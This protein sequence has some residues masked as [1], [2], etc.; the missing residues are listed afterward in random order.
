MN[1]SLWLDEATTA[2]VSKMSFVEI[3]TKFLPNDFHPPFYYLFMKYWVNIFGYS[4]ISLRLPSVIFA[5]LTVYLVYKMFG[6]I[7][8]ILLATA[9]LLFYYAQEARM[10]SLTTFLVTL[11]FYLF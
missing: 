10:Y 11:V 1:E 3:F 6:K 4:E 2:L 5:L 9:P 8:A 7:A